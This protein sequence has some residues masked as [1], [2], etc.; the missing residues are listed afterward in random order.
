MQFQPVCPVHFI[1]PQQLH[2]RFC[3]FRPGGVPTPL[4]AIDELPSWLQIS[5]P[6]PDTYIGLQPVS[7][8]YIPREG[9]YEVTCINCSS[10]VSS[11]NQ[12]M[13]DRN[14][15]VQS[16]QSA[17]SANKN[18]NGTPCNG[19][20]ENA[21]TV[22]IPKF[23]IG[24]SIGN[25]SFDATR[26]SPVIGLYSTNGSPLAPRN[27]PLPASTVSTASQPSSFGESILGSEA[28]PS[29]SDSSDTPTTPTDSSK[30]TSIA[31]TRSL[32]GAVDQLREK[33]R[34]KG[35]SADS[36][37]GT[38]IASTRSLTAAV[39]RLRQKIKLKG[40]SCQAS[41][42][43]KVHKA[44]PA[45]FDAVWHKNPNYHRVDSESHRMAKLSRRRRTRLKQ[46]ELK[47]SSSVG[48]MKEDDLKLDGWHKSPKSHRVH[49]KSQR[50][51]KLPRIKLKGRKSTL[52]SSVETNS[53]TK[54]LARRE[55][56]AERLLHHH[57]VDRKS[58]YW[59]MA[60]I[61]K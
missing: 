50:T 32:T 53:S 26:Q 41:F 47:L 54:R 39:E 13:S 35:S 61:P 10:S 1:R 27:I 30:G 52:A 43:R 8:S 33:K 9:E 3:I 55:R 19:T 59:H 58:R 34:L 21:A 46:S 5:N 7:P 57:D 49:S 16:P 36:S 60:K 37:N 24:F 48:D 2:P 12:S 28:E 17:I 23:P 14:E 56:L 22:T 29:K 40:S 45:D 51:V 44:V 15:D 31:S 38:S 18:C 6:S 42:H 20:G 25:P 11:V 4:I